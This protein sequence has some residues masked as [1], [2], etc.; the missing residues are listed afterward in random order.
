M[1]DNPESH[2]TDA[3]DASDDNLVRKQCEELMES[4]LTKMRECGFGPDDFESTDSD[5]STEPYAQVDDKN[6]DSAGVEELQ[7]ILKKYFVSVHESRLAACGRTILTMK[8]NHDLAAQSMMLQSEILHNIESII[9]NEKSAIRI[10]EKSIKDKEEF[11][12]DKKNSLLEKR[13]AL[14]HCKEVIARVRLQRDKYKIVSLELKKQVESF[15]ERSNGMKC[16]LSE[17]KGWVE[18][19]KSIIEI[20]GELQN[21]ITIHD[22][23]IGIVLEPGR[24]FTSEF[25]FIRSNN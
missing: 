2:A 6:Q 7:S 10:D 3:A 11:H 8:M 9:R 5:D 25:S 16:N 20:D 4:L 21:L 14:Q 23:E 18:M 17:I 13:Q 12:R 22:I 1:E 15:G 19:A 24:E